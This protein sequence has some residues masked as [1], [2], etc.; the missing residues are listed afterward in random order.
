MAFVQFLHTDK[1]LNP[2]HATDILTDLRL[3]FHKNGDVTEENKKKELDKMIRKVIK[4]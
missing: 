3:I 1:F 4:G 2:A